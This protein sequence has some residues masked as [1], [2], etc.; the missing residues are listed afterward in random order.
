[1]TAIASPRPPDRTAG[2]HDDNPGP[3]GAQRNE[4][5][6]ARTASAPIA[7]PADATAPTKARTRVADNHSYAHLTPRAP[8]RVTSS[9]FLHD[10]G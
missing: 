4:P 10:P 5:L 8:P 7:T 1:M 2:T 3:D 6:P 9:G